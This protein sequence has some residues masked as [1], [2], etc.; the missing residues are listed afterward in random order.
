MSGRLVSGGLITPGARAVVEASASSVMPSDA[1][2]MCR[3]PALRRLPP[4]AA[5]GF[6]D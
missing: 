4:A 2:I 5:S 1:E 3:S 6:L